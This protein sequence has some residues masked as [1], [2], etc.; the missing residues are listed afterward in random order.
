M[1][2]VLLRHGGVYETDVHVQIAVFVEARQAEGDPVLATAA[3]DAAG[4]EEHVED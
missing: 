4:F 2:F 1:L 3:L